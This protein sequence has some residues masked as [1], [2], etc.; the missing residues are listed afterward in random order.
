VVA[1][2]Y[3]LSSA[4]PHLFGSRLS[5]FDDDLRA[6]LSQTSST[7]HFSEQMAAIT[8]HLWH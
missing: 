5:A 6:L 8:L 4:T 3:S 1:S 2:V 7:G